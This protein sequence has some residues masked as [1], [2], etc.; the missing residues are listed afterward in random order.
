MFPKE[1]RVPRDIIKKVLFEGE[2][3]QTELF[4]LRKKE[5][6]LDHNRFAV[7]VSKK[8]A[9]TAVK[10][11]YLKRLFKNSLKEFFTDYDTNQKP[12]LD[13]VLILNS[14][15]ATTTKDAIIDTLSKTNI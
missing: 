8:V 4:L 9:K 12:G 14:K 7:V 2:K 13:I 5:N 10:R 1:N 11:H 15:S 3:I 6:N